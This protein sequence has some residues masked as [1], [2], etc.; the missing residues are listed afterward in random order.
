V[1]IAALQGGSPRTP[2][3]D[4]GLVRPDPVREV[5]DPGVLET[6]VLRM[7]EARRAHLDARYPEAIAGYRDLLAGRLPWDMGESVRFFLGL[8]LLRAG[9]SPEAVSAFDAALDASPATSW[10][11]SILYYRGE[12]RLQEGDAGGAAAD[13]SAAGTPQARMKLTALAQP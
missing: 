1:F 13:W 12:A 10:R 8:A 11:R 2:A 4:P 6:A 9:S 3:R 7:D 5:V